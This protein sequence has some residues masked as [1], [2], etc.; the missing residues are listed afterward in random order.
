[1]RREEQ[2]QALEAQGIAALLLG[3]PGELAA[4]VVGFFPGGADVIFDTTG[5]RLDAAVPALAAF[6]RLAIIA[7]PADGH[8]PLPAFNL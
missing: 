3:E 6:G 7:A 1:M 4:Q 5:F 2:R 8:V